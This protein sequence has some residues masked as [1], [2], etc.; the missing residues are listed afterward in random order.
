M[1]KIIFLGGSIT[2]AN[3]NWLPYSNGLG[4]GYVSILSSI[5]HEKGHSY[6]LKN[7]GHDGSTVRGV[8]RSLERDCISQMPDFVSILVGTNDAGVSMNTG[9]CL[10]EQQFAANYELL[11]TRILERTHAKIICMSPFIFPHPQEYGNW[12]PDI[13]YIEQ[14]IR[15]LTEQYGLPFF[16]LHDMLNASAKVLGYDAIT[17]D[18]IHLTDY[19]HGLIAK[20]W[21][22]QFLFMM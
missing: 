1:E 14:V 12:T 8:L 15:Q 20:E 9:V 11:L 10:K 4:N 18:G 21:Y 7:K 17:T 2:D 16:P 6:I 3:H 13:L 19:G 5:L 22:Q